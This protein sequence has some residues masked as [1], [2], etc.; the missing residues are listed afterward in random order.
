[1]SVVTI[2]PFSFIEGYSRFNLVLWR[3]WRD[4]PFHALGRGGDGRKEKD[5]RWAWM[6]ENGGNELKEK[7]SLLNVVV[8]C[9]IIQ[10]NTICLEIEAY[11]S[12]K[13]QKRE[14][15]WN[16]SPYSNAV[17]EAAREQREVSWFPV[18][19][20][21]LSEWK[22]EM[23]KWSLLGV[24][25]HSSLL[26]QRDQKCWQSTELQHSIF[27]FQC[28]AWCYDVEYWW[29]NHKT[30]TGGYVHLGLSFLTN[31]PVESLIFHIP[32]QV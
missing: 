23:E 32:C 27:N 20:I 5:G 13:I 7:L 9:E 31:I 4:P 28:A 19:F 16:W 2:S 24:V 3:G 15:F 12:N 1:M 21:F 11:K 10:H 22:M 29:K 30:M 6:K 17:A 26:K 14:S 25:V 18:H 8:E